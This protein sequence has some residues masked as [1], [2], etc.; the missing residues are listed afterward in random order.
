MLEQGPK[1]DKFQSIQERVS[2]MR[3]DF[4]EPQPIHNARLFLLRQVIHNYSDDKTVRIFKSFVPAL[5]KSAVGTGLLINDMI[6]PGP[7]TKPKVEEH[8]LRQIDMAMLGGYSAKQRT[9]K[10]FANLLSTADER[11][12]VGHLSDRFP[13]S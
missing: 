8:G 9:L 6:L 1:R 7:N 4:Y 2:F 13:K 3:Y 11:L 12:K 5:E 10:E